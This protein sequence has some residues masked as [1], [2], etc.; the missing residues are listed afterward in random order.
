MTNG[1]LILGTVTIGQAPRTDL[2]PEIKQFLGDGV[3][4]LEAG[5]LDGLTLAEVQK[6]Y[7][8]PG[9][10]VLITRMADGTQV[11]VAEKHIVPRM[12]GK[13]DRLVEQGAGVVLLA[14][15]GEF[16]EFECRKLLIEP[17]KVLFDTVKSVA[18]G[19]KLGVFIP[20]IDQVD[21]AQR[22]WSAVS[23]EVFVQAVSPYG[24]AGDKTAGADRLKQAGVQVAVLDCI[25]YTLRDK[26]AVKEKL[27]VPVVL[28]RSMVA[29]V[30]AELL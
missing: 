6:L 19:M 2:I 24:C 29:R 23:H 14:C 22:R 11:K 15:T 13:I 28:A 16:P 8:D 20:D 17:N 21:Y 12:Q 7:P 1:K 5:A 9:D 27:Q 10:N 30:I 26:Q 25:G 3:E 4:I 18:P